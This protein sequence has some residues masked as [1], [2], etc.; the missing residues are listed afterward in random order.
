MQQNQTMQ[1]QQKWREEQK[2]INTE[3]VELAQRIRAP[4]TCTQLIHE[5]GSWVKVFRGCGLVV[6]R[7]GDLF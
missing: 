1:E 5:S 3:G 7:K 6:G 4:L 2:E